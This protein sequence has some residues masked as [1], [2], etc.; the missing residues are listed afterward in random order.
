MSS[1]I[2]LSNYRGVQLSADILRPRTPPIIDHSL[3]CDIKVK[4][5]VNLCHQLRFQ[6]NINCCHCYKQILFLV[7]MV[8]VTLSLF[9][10]L[11]SS[12]FF[13]CLSSCFYSR[14]ITPLSSI[15]ECLYSRYPFIYWFSI[16]ESL[17]FLRLLRSSDDR[18]LVVLGGSTFSTP[19]QWLLYKHS[20]NCA[21]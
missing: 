2:P 1:N 21:V 4:I 12:F 17:I 20:L 3:C 13:C 11:S 6:S 8:W 10:S 15:F 19:V 5:S 14:T 7:T 9:C 16:F 18:S